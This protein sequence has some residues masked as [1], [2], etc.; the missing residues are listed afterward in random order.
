VTP[1]QISELIEYLKGLGELAV[2]KGFEVA[3]KQVSVMLATRVVY[4]LVGIIFL[5]VAI[6]L[7]KGATNMKKR[8]ESQEPEKDIWGEWSRE[9]KFFLLRAASI[10]FGIASIVCTADSIIKIASYLI[11]PEWYAIQLMLDLVR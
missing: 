5:I 2:T 10:V 6:A 1:E 3:M 9:D 11:N 7:W 4:L 8:F